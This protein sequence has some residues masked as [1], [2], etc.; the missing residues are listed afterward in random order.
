[1]SQPRYSTEGAAK[2]RRGG[3]STSL[4]SRN[5]LIGLSL[6]LYSSSST[7]HPEILL[8]TT[9]SCHSPA[10]YPLL[11]FMHAINCEL[12]PVSPKAQ[13]TGDLPVPTPVLCQNCLQSYGLFFCSSNDPTSPPP[14]AVCPW[15]CSACLCR[16]SPS[17]CMVDT[18]S[19][20]I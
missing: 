8:N 19:F 12:H 5:I 14:Q 11:P 9:R 15:D 6:S 10:Q 13:V 1:M 20:S 7:Q 3:D 18:F 16:P 4:G 2:D 17:L